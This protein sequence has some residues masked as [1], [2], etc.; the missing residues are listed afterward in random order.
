MGEHGVCHRL[1]P[2]EQYKKG[3]SPKRKRFLLGLPPFL[4]QGLMT[5]LIE[6]NG[7]WLTL[8]KLVELLLELSFSGRANKLVNELSVLEEQ[9]SRDVAHAILHGDVLVLLDVALAYHD[10]ALI[11]V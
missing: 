7:K 2:E 5:S 4:Y 1:V 11:F 6:S 10:L 9:D 8:D 3:E